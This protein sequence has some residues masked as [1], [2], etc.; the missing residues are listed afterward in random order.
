MKGYSTD[1]SYRVDG[2]ATL[3]PGIER[4]DAGIAAEDDLEK[5]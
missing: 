5:S 2:T 4:A 1:A 3:V